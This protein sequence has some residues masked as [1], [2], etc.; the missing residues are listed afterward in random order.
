ML[1][2]AWISVVC[3]GLCVPHAHEYM[4]E[5]THD[6]TGHVA[7]TLAIAAAPRAYQPI[8]SALG[9]LL[10]QGEELPVDR[11][12]VVSCAICLC[13]LFLLDRCIVVCCAPICAAC[14]LPVDRCIVESCATMVAVFVWLG[15]VGLL[16][17]GGLCNLPVLPNPLLDWIVMSSALLQPGPCSA[18]TQGESWWSTCQAGGWWSKFLEL[19]A[20]PCVSAEHV[21]GGPELLDLL[22]ASRLLRDAALFQQ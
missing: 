8:E 9:S 19:A 3:I 20:S 5:Q 6:I 14:L 11:C 17:C 4:Y 12:I 13:C 15:L 22:A 1:V 2:S 16:H 7:H 18:L 10:A 21:S